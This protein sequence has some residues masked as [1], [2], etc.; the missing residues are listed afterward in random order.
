[1]TNKEYMTNK[2][3]LALYQEVLEEGIREP[4]FGEGRSV[5]LT[6]IKVKFPFTFPTREIRG[7][8]GEIHVQKKSIGIKRTPS[9]NYLM[10]ELKI[11]ELLKEEIINLFKEVLTYNSPNKD[12]NPYQKIFWNKL[13]DS[14]RKFL[15]KQY[16]LETGIWT[17]TSNQIVNIKQEII[18]IQNH[19]S[20]LVKKLDVLLEQQDNS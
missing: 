15:K 4:Y 10:Y 9:S 8:I 3:L 20:T 11:H 5:I 18:A 16:P 7:Q 19:L 2:E 12:H 1:M 17:E 13:E 14:L 6:S